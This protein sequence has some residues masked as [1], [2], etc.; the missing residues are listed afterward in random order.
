MKGKNAMRDVKRSL[1]DLDE[2]DRRQVIVYWRWLALRAKIRRL[3]PRQMLVPLMLVQI[4]AF[5]LSLHT[6][7]EWALWLVSNFVIV[8]LGMFPVLLIPPHPPVRAHWVRGA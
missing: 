5:A 1:L 6:E 4:A 3:T 2:W 7:Y 8:G